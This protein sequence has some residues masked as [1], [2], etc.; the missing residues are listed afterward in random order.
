MQRDSVEEFLRQRNWLD[1]LPGDIAKSISIE[2]AEL[3]ELF[4]WQNPS[5]KDVK[6]DQQLMQDIRNEI[7]DI[8]I[9]AIELSIILGFDVEKEVVRK[10]KEVREKYPAGEMLENR[11]DGRSPANDKYFQRK[12]SQRES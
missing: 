9:Y 5:A 4:Q 6:S 1:L 8:T 7:A 11:Q 3:L 2:A 12:R 10:L